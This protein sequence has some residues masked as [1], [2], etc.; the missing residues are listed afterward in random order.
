MTDCTMNREALDAYLDGDLAPTDHARVTEH[1]AGCPSCQ[2]ELE[3]VQALLAATRTLPRAILP[4][5]DLWNDIER[6]IAAT[7]EARRLPL[8]APVGRPRWAPRLAAAIG[9]LLLGAALAT[10]W[11]HR[12]APSAF[13]ATQARYAAATA[14][15]AERLARDTTTLNP[16]TRAVV[17]RNLAIVDAAIRE[18]ES[19]LGNDPGSAALQQMLVARYE[20]RIALLRHATRRGGTES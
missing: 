2:A 20:Q 7:P 19:A 17:E 5:R 10:L 3:R 11:Q 12:Q 15:L 9:F 6:R 16:G 14:D 1:L 13:A 8:S 4:E 18:A